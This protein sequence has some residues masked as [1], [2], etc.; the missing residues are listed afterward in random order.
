MQQAI[1]HYM[2]ADP[3]TVGVH[4]SVHRARQIMEACGIRHLPVVDGERIVGVV[5]ERDIRILESCG[6]PAA[7]TEVSQAM[8][9][10]PFV[11]GPNA[12]LASVARTMAERKYGSAIVLEDGRLVGIFCAVDALHALSD[13]FTEYYSAPTSD[14]WGRVLLHGMKQ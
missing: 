11:V 6:R 5:T 13:L 3:R 9:P 8:T 4:E 12:P 14:R 1:K 10:D 2:T 7:T